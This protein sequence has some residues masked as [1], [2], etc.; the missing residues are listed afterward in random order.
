MGFDEVEGVRVAVAAHQEVDINLIK[1]RGVRREG[2][3]GAVVDKAR[4][5]LVNDVDGLQVLRVYVRVASCRVEFREVGMDFPKLRG[6]LSVRR[7]RLLIR[8]FRQGEIAPRG[9]DSSSVDER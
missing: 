7:E 6:I 2:Q 4:P 8:A 9:S 1:S 3:L 5:V